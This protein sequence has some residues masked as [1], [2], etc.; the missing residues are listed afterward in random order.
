[1]VSSLNACSYATDGVVLPVRVAGHVALDFCNT[2]AGW[3]ELEQ[4]DYLRGYR[5]LVLWARD[6]GLVEPEA[7]E[8][9]KDR[10]APAVLRRA[11]RL[12]A[13][14][15]ETALGGNVWAAVAAEA[16]R[17]AAA[18]RLTPAGWRLPERDELP[19][20]AIARAAG[21][22]LLSAHAPVGA[23]PGRQC[24]WVFVDPRG[25]RR[26]CSMATCGNR[27]KQRRYAE[28]ARVA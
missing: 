12:R 20:L 16:E 1:V 18:A 26:W 14:L 4:K 17:A 15:R 9:L 8:R 10:E 6:A 22:F 3:G 27:A 2:L 11:R 19:L 25:R 24:G 28:R 21:D 23:C 13:A 5:E 7:A